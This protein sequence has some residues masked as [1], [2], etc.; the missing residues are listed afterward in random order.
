[1]PLCYFVHTQAQFKIRFVQDEKGAYTSTAALCLCYSKCVLGIKGNAGEVFRCA[2]YCEIIG[3]LSRSS[4]CHRTLLIDSKN[5]F[6][7]AF[8]LYLCQT[9]RSLDDVQHMLMHLQV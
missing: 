7:E 1:M 8:I 6:L 3:H 2:Q 9:R 5:K 4:R